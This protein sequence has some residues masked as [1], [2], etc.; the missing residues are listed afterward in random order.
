MDLTSPIFLFLFLPIFVLVYSLTVKR[1]KLLIGITGSILFYSWGNSQHIFLMIGLVLFAYLTARLMDRWRDTRLFLF[2]LWGGIIVTLGLL[3]GYKL[4][5]SLAY[6][7]G[8][9]Y[10]TFQIIA[11]FVDVSKN[12]GNYE[13]DILKFSFYL[14]LFPKIPVGPIVPYRQVRSQIEDL[15][16]DPQH[17]ADGFRRFIGGLAKKILI[18][19]TLATVV[20]PIFNLQSPVIPP[21]LAWLV[22]LS[23]S[24]QLYY[25]FSGYTDMAIGLGQ[26][27]GVRFMENFDF[28]YLSKSISD[29]WRRWHISLSTWFREVVFY[30][31][32]RR[33]FKWFGQQI[34]ILIVFMLTGLWHGFTRNFFFWGLLHG[35]VLAF[36]STYWGRRIRNLWA[37][38]QHMYALGVILLG[39]VI[40]RSPTLD[41]AY[42]YLRRLA[43]ETSGIQTLPFE[44]TRPLPFI[45]PSFLV[46]LTV[47]ILLCLPLSQWLTK[48]F[49]GF[50]KERFAVR[51]LAD[52][53]LV[54]ALLASLAS[55]SSAAYQPGIYGSF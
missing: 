21:A 9:S 50:N 54:L 1:L 36:E 5:T 34:N 38:I 48:W 15:K 47:G 4:Q 31:L 45:E 32:E 16:S 18:A 43:G 51:L 33:R 20:V 12:A 37:P 27:M 23:Y 49:P 24:L 19:D 29:F 7:L 30:P 39:W 52:T 10:V 3:I 22:I 41:F 25:D 26:M 11:Y 40:F 44:L 35:I 6:P 42:D 17:I 8:L 13:T 55:A 28:P 14:L 46:A 2:I 53:G